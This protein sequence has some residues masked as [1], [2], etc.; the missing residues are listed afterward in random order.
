[1]KKTILLIVMLIITSMTF[2]QQKGVKWMSFEEVKAA[3][4]QQPKKIFID[5]YT[6]WCGW[7]K[8]MDKDTFSDSIIASYINENYY[9]IKMNAETTDT[10]SIKGHQFINSNTNTTGKK[11]SHDLAIALLQGK[12]SFPSYVILNEKLEI[13]QTIPGY[14][15]ARNFEPMLH[16]FAEERYNNIEWEN[17]K[18][19]FKSAFPPEK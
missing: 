13:L 12:M 3:M 14:H 19:E 9:A 15:T 1:M 17:F 7:C 11:G 4:T 18:K 10:I 16:Y 2:A 5:V 8:R 6:D